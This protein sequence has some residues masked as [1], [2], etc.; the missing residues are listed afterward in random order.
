MEAAQTREQSTGH[1]RT[2]IKASPMG[3]LAPGRAT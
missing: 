3:G 1:N 2:G